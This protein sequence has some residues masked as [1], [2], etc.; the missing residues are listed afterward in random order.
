MVKQNQI[1]FQI[2]FQNVWCVDRYLLWEFRVI[3]CGTKCALDIFKQANKPKLLGNNESERNGKYANKQMHSIWQTDESTNRPCVCYLPKC[4]QIFIIT[5]H[6]KS[7]IDCFDFYLFF[8]F[9]LR[10]N[11]ERI[12]YWWFSFG[13]I[14]DSVWKSNIFYLNGQYKRVSSN[15]NTIMFS[16]WNIH[17]NRSQS[18]PSIAHCW[19][20]FE[21]R[22][23]MKFK[24]FSDW[25]DA[26]VNIEFKF[27]MNFI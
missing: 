3:K 23:E 27:W 12:F 21:N 1:A 22:I 16:L 6:T 17:L 26:R 11:I 24:K 25:V 14:K 5:L 19:V 20:F 18:I 15:R 9:K 8:F 13:H 10:N 4:K 7:K 2:L